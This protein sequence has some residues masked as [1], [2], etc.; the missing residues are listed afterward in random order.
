MS[1]ATWRPKRARCSAHMRVIR[2]WPLARRHKLAHIDI[3]PEGGPMSCGEAPSI[4]IGRVHPVPCH[5][6]RRTDVADSSYRPAGPADAIRPSQFEASPQILSHAVVTRTTWAV[7][8]GRHHAARPMRHR[9]FRRCVV[10]VH[11]KAFLHL[12][13]PESVLAEV[14]GCSD[15]SKG[16]V[17]ASTVGRSMSHSA[18]C[19]RFRRR[20]CPA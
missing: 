8:L 17:V 16:A 2:V 11:L 13:L 4:P 3:H 6:S 20:N 14:Q 19:H 10:F 9:V 5:I 7:A 1:T 18:A 12:V 15:R